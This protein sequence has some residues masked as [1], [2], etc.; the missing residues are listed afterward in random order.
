MI[1]G[2]T[3]FKEGAFQRAYEIYTEALKII[4]L[5]PDSKSKVLFNRALMSSKMGNIR[6]A[7][8]DCTESLQINKIYLKAILLRAQCYSD[9]CDYSKCIKDYRAALKI[10]DSFEIEAA[11]IKAKFNKSQAQEKQRRKYNGKKYKHHQHQQQPS[12]NHYE[13][14]GINRNATANDIRRAYKNLALKHHPDRHT[15]A[16]EKFRREQ[17]RIFKEIGQAY[18]VLSDPFK[19]RD[20]DYAFYM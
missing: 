2:T 4:P 8:T 12:R 5:S 11:L 14:L 20:Y 13:I 9:L 19:R 17:E 15:N 1:L 18:K 16:T 3:L 7:I 6:D 10:N